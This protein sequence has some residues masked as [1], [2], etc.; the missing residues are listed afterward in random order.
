M[1][2]G[3]GGGHSKR[4]SEGMKGNKCLN[5]FCGAS[6]SLHPC[7]FSLFKKFCVCVLLLEGPIRGSISIMKGR[8]LIGSVSGPNCAVPTAN[9]NYQSIAFNTSHLFR[10]FV[11]ISCKI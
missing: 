9:L 3:G 5:Q 10:C 8:I 1:G 6:M 4:S 11:T 7:R 2:A